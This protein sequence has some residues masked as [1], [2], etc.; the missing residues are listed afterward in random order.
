[1]SRPTGPGSSLKAGRP[2]K[3]KDVRLLARAVLMARRGNSNTTTANRIGVHPNTLQDWLATGRSGAGPPL[4]LRFARAYDKA[5]S[6]WTAEQLAVVEDTAQSRQQNTWQAAA[7][8]LER[9]DPS[10]WGKREYRP[11]MAERPQLPNIG[12]L[13]LNGND[14]IAAAS[15]DFLRAVG[16]GRPVIPERAGM[17]GEP[18][19]EPT[20]GEWEPLDVDPR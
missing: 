16:S 7:W 12:V 15:R 13:I 9:R 17:G 2:P 11:D 19:E 1:M 10:N 3:Y 20:E 8:L 4:L 6:L 5:L 14:E 18:E